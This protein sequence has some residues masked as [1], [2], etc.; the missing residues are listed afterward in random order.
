MNRPTVLYISYDGLLEPLGRSQVLA[1]AKK[2]SPDFR[3]VILT[4]EKSR[5]LKDSDRVARTRNEVTDWGIFWVPLAYHKRPRLFATG[6]D[7]AHGMAMALLLAVR[8]G[9]NIVHSRSYVAALIGLGVKFATRI[10]FIFDMR[11]FWVD[12]AVEKGM[13][14]RKSGWYRLG[15]FLERQYLL[16][17]NAVVSL[18]QSAVDEMGRWEFLRNR[19]INFRVIT[20]CC[21]LDQFSVGTQALPASRRN[22]VLGYV[23]NIGIW[24]RFDLVLT[25]FKYVLE[26][27]PDAKLLVINRDQQSVIWESVDSAGI[28]RNLV[29]VKA[30]SHENMAAEIQKMDASAFFIKPSFAKLASAPTKLGELLAC[31]V[32]CLTSRGIGDMDNQIENGK[33]GVLIDFDQMDQPKALGDAIYRLVEIANSSQTKANCRASAQRHFSLIEGAKQYRRLYFGLLNN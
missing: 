25:C 28:P 23:G 18:T 32:P 19:N 31:G 6:F 20:T 21:D 24:Y 27:L 33:S 13:W 10:P 29:E 11:G 26:Q 5:D 8:H 7:I 14:R 3:M 9:A 2:L 17:A 22:F 30:V 12:E 16:K 15:K 4:F 1:Y